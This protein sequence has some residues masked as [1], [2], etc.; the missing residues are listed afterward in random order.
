MTRHVVFLNAPPRAGKDSLA[1]YVVAQRPF[2]AMKFA[3]PIRRAVRA[4]WN[5]SDEEVADFEANK[6][7]PRPLFN[8]DSYRQVLIDYS[9]G[10]VKPYFGQRAFGA[11]A[12]RDA[13]AAGDRPII[14][15]DAGFTYEEQ[16]FI[17]G[18]GVIDTHYLIVRIVRPSS[19]WDSRHRLREIDFQQYAPCIQFVDLMNDRSLPEFLNDGLRV[20]DAWM[21]DHT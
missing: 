20:I 6:D 14:F 11:Q 8:G 10:Y 17:E 18:Y 12:V 1:D 19:R 16:A 13:R 4:H 2:Y 21:N 9:E 7:E 5:L 15:S 3:A